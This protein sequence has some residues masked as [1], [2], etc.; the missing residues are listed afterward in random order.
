[1]ANG[2][3]DNDRCVRECR[4]ISLMTI[5]AGVNSEDMRIISISSFTIETAMHGA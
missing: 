5:P 3:K 1:M 4:Q 2:S